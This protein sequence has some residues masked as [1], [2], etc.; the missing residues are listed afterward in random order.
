M[1]VIIGPDGRIADY[2]KKVNPL[3]YPKQ[4]LAKVTR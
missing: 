3:F 4:A 2:E 1:G